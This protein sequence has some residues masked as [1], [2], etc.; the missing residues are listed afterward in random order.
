MHTKCVNFFFLGYRI[1]GDAIVGT[2]RSDKLTLATSLLLNAVIIIGASSTLDSTFSSTGKLLAYDL[3][4]AR[5]KIRRNIWN[6]RL[7]MGLLGIAGAAMVHASPTILSATTIS[8]TMALGLAPPFVLHPWKRP[9]RPSF[10][11]SALI[12]LGVGIT[13]AYYDNKENEESP[14]QI[15]EG[16]YAGL[17]AWNVFG[18]GAT[19]GAYVLLGLLFPFRLKEP[20]AVEPEDHQSMLPETLA[21]MP[22]KQEAKVHPDAE[23]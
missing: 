10:F 20:V 8:G 14:I 9:G 17:L 7:S 19:F 5:G 13:F 23:A 4:P 22:E 16:P 21:S 15:G 1:E 12:G 11:A 18:F 2:A 3:L 6:A